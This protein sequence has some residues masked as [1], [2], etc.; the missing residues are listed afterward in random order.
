MVDGIVVVSSEQEKQDHPIAVVIPIDADWSIRIEAARRLRD[1]L[2]GK[3][4][5]RW[6]THQRCRRIASALR[7]TD[8]RQA[9]ATFRDIAIEYFGRDRV[10][11][12]PWKT[13]ALKAQTARLARYG[14]RLTST[15][16]RQLLRGRSASHT[17]SR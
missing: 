1:A 13:S 7:T 8:A 17:Q 9:D 14:R 12:D 15:G 4:P 11:S 3:R 10:A 6:F 16:Y 2:V 5:R